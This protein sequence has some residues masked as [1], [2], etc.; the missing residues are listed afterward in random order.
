MVKRNI[1]IAIIIIVLF[2]ILAIAGF[3]IYAVNNHVSF[4][5]KK[6]GDEESVEDALAMNAYVQIAEIKVLQTEKVQES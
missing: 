2:L 5:S 4:F 3:A 6:K 1:T